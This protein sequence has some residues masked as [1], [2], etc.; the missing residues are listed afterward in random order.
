[1][2][3]VVVGGPWEP[4]CRRSLRRSRRQPERDRDPRRWELSYFLANRPRRFGGSSVSSDECL[5]STMAPDATREGES[6]FSRSMTFFFVARRSTN[7]CS[8]VRTHVLG[9]DRPTPLFMLQG[10]H[11]RRTRAATLQGRPLAEPVN[12]NETAAC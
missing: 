3:L 2:P 7:P 6:A 12:M 1:M 8:A 11:S 10:Y 9:C 4:R 5:A